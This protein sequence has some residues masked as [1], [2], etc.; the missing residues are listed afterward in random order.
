MSKILTSQRNG[1]EEVFSRGKEPCF[2]GTQDSAGWRRCW[3]KASQ[4]AE[5]AHCRVTASIHETASLHL[6]KGVTL[7]PSVQQ[8]W[9]ILSPLPRRW[10]F[11]WVK[12]TLNHILSLLEK[13]ALSFWGDMVRTSS[14]AIQSLWPHSVP[15]TEGSWASSPQELPLLFWKFS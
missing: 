11:H 9:C 6:S 14:K 15:D 2:K 10:H 1:E 7:G 13:N 12:C 3:R 8:N 5:R 4:M